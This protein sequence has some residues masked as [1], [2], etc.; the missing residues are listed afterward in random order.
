MLNKF[1]TALAHIRHAKVAAD[2]LNVM[3]IDEVVA[4]KAYNDLKSELEYAL[5]AVA[6]V[7]DE[8]REKFGKIT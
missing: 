1:E 8:L 7:R 5:R 4:Q 2:E 3:P 6:K